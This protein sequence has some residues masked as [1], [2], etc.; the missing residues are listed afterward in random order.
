MQLRAENPVIS[1]LHS[2]LVLSAGGKEGHLEELSG[3]VASVGDV[4]QIGQGALRR[5]YL[6]LNL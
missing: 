5:S 2:A 6:A 4:A 1:Q 3:P